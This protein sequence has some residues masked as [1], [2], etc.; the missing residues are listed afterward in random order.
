MPWENILPA[1][2]DTLLTISSFGN[3]L[4]QARNLNQTLDVIGEATQLERTI[5]G[6]LT[7]FSAPQFRKYSSKIT[8]PNDVNAP[9]FDGVFPGMQVE[10][11]CAVGLSFVTGLPGAPFREPVSGSLYI[12]GNYTFYR[13]ELDMLVRSLE[14]HFDE[15]KNI[16]GWTLNCEEI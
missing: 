4:Y 3:M 15:W 13:P 1:P 5:N 7:D 14:T 8:I 6:V 16:V 10:V 9:P 12:D 2:D 11:G